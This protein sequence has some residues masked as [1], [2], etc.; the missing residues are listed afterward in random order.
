MTEGFTDWLQHSRVMV[1]AVDSAHGRLRIRGES[2]SDLACHER[3]VVLAEDGRDLP[4]DALNPGDI[5]RI[6]EGVQGVARV[7]VL[8]RAWEEIASPE[9]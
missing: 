1:V 4:L 2:C 8:R 7:V 6:D 3:T 5:V 9:L